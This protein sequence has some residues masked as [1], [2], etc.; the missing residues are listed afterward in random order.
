MTN[1]NARSSTIL[2][3]LSTVGNRNGGKNTITLFDI[4]TMPRQ[5]IC[6]TIHY[7]LLVTWGITQEGGC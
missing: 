2:Q 7:W 3:T 1:T 5:K 4:Q 6:Y